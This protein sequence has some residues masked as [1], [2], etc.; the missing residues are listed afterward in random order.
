LS[1]RSRDGQR[2]LVR[3]LV[4]HHD[5]PTISAAGNTGKGTAS[6]LGNG[7]GVPGSNGYSSESPIAS[8]YDGCCVSLYTPVVRPTR[9][10]S[11]FASPM[12]PAGVGTWNRPP[13]GNVLPADL[14]V[15]AAWVGH[16]GQ[17][18][19]APPPHVAKPLPR[20]AR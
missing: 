20:D 17:R 16:A 15:R 12:T 13:Y 3:D 1:H 6:H 10:P 11:A 2:L 19:A 9:V 4:A 5:L 7:T 18:P 8:K 14:G